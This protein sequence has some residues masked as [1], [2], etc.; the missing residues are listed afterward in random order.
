MRVWTPNQIPQSTNTKILEHKLRHICSHLKFTFKLISYLQEYPLFRY[1][2]LCTSVVWYNLIFPLW[3]SSRAPGKLWTKYH[4]KS[5]FGFGVEH[6]KVPGWLCCYPAVWCARC[7]T[8]P[9]WSQ[10]GSENGLRHSPIGCVCGWGRT[11]NCWW[12]EEPLP[13]L[14]MDGL[15]NFVLM[16]YLC[17]A[18]IPPLE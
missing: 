11:F 15:C 4:V 17:N 9:L 2:S 12:W 3:R 16:Y 6:A 7:R 8:L 10:T 14:Y 18:K 5:S 13:F 1:L